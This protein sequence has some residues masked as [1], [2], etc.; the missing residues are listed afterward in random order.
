MD[1]IIELHFTEELKQQ[2]CYWQ[3]KELTHSGN[4][5]KRKAALVFRNPSHRPDLITNS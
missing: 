1:P 3:T 4:S 5:Q 2:L